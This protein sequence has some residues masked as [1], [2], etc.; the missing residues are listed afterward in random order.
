MADVFPS[1]RD[2]WLVAVIWMAG[3]LLVGTAWIPIIAGPFGALRIPLA[4]LH[5]AV[6]GFAFWVLYGTGYRVGDRDL[7]VR[8]GPFRWRIPIDAIASITPSS[9]PISSPACSLDRLRIAYRGAR[10]ERALLVSP[11]DRAGFLAAL[12]AR[13]AAIR[14]AG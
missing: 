1:K 10:G 13:G 2:G 9:N 7:L 8:S 11:A 14:I 5:L 3:V 6:A 12:A 4:I